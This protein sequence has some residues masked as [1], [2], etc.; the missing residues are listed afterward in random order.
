MGLKEN[1]SPHLEKGTDRHP[2][3]GAGAVR[4]RGHEPAPFAAE[5][6]G[7]AWGERWDWLPVP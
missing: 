3:A 4:D 7:A 2:Q 1:M 5:A 6:E